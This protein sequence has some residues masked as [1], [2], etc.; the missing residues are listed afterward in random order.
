MLMGRFARF[1]RYSPIA[2]CAVCLGWSPTLLN[3]AADSLSVEINNPPTQLTVSL[4]KR[5][6][7]VYAFGQEQHKPFI[8]ELYTLSGQNVLANAPSDHLHH[9]GIMYAVEVNGVDFWHESN[10]TGIQHPAQLISQYA[11]KGAGGLPE[12]GFTQLI[13]WVEP[14]DRHTSS[15]ATALLVEHRRITFTADESNREILVRWDSS[16]EVGDK[17]NRVRLSGDVYNGLGLR[18][19]RAFDAVAVHRNSEKEPDLSGSRTDVSQARWSSIAFDLPGQPLTLAVFGDP[20]N[21]QGHAQFFTMLTPFAYI[22]ATQGVDKQPL[23]YSAGATFHLSYLI[24]V[25]EGF[26]APGFLDQ[27]AQWQKP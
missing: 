8:K 6:M 18:F 11:G 12:A 16:F 14:A 23:E 17:A 22:T 27:R 1:L 25:Y 5:P 26:K 9:H 4:N 20:G 24:A 13:Y 19:P 2:A 10:N 7:L 21:A 15:R 3:A